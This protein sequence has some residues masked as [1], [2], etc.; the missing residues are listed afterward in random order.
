MRSYRFL[1]SCACSLMMAMTPT[2]LFAQRA[3]GGVNGTVTDSTGAVVAGATATLTNQD[4]N[5]VNHATTSNTGYFVF[6]DVTPGPYVLTITKQGF[7]LVELP[8]FNLVVNQTLTE[9]ETMSVGSTTEIVK[10]TAGEEGV[11]LQTSS[12]ELGSVIQTKE[13]QQLP[14][15]GRNFTSLLILS[16]GVTPVSTAQVSGISTTDAGISAIPGTSF[17]KVSFFGQQNRETLYYMDGIVNTDIRG[18]IYGFL[19]SSMQWSSSRCSRTSTALSTAWSSAS[20]STC[21]RNLAQTTS[22]DR[23]GSSSVTMTSTRATAIAT[24]AARA[25]VL[26]ARRALRPHRPCTMF[27]I[28]SAQP[29]A[30]PSC[31]TSCSS[32]AR[33]KAGATP[34]LASL[35]HWCRAS[36]SLQVIFPAPQSLSIST[37]FITLF[38]QMHGN[39]LRGAAVPVRRQRQPDYAGQQHP[40]WRNA[41]PEDSCVHDRSGD[42]CLREGVLSGGELARDGSI[43]LQLHGDQAADQ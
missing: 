8:R 39:Q 19:P 24:S 2:A 18:A 9:N 4:T 28:S 20:S 37:N 11:M 36:R 30:G 13:I 43:G 42:A 41:L 15:N 22:M 38:H 31:T 34:N 10:V 35:R 25:D 23:S 16:P 17:F 14:L 7:K 40:D 6:L 27:R 33:M 29:A 26:P 3:T 12:S 21:S 32:T 1:I 5:I